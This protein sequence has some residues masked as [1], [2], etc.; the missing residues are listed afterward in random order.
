MS[1]VVCPPDLA[2]GVAVS[3]CSERGELGLPL[4]EAC[5]ETDLQHGKG[6]PASGHSRHGFSMWWTRDFKGKTKETPPILE[7]HLF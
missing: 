7:L 1:E 3:E 2:A 5:A 4:G 6:D